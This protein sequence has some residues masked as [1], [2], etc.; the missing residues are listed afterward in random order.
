MAVFRSKVCFSA[1]LMVEVCSLCEG[2]V[3][4][5]QMSSSC[6]IVTSAAVEA[7]PLLEGYCVIK[8]TIFHAVP[9]DLGDI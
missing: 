4:A 6:V 3:V 5:L 8:G 9:E 7:A 1:S 2:A